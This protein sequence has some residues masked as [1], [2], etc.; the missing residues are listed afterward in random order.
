[1]PM[2]RWAELAPQWASFDEADPKRVVIKVKS[3]K[4]MAPLEKFEERLKKKENFMCLL[5]WHR[6]ELEGNP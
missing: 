4:R 5:T 6:K 2:I 1:M 3:F